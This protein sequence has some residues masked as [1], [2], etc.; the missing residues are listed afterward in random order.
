MITKTIQEKLFDELLH[1]SSK[2][3]IFIK[4]FNSELSHIKI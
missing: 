4:N 1:F 2:I 3:A